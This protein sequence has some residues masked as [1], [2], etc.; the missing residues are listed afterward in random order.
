VRKR[1]VRV[2]RWLGKFKVVYRDGAGVRKAPGFPTEEEAQEH[3]VKIRR[4]LQHGTLLDDGLTVRE[5]VERFLAS[6]KAR[7]A[8]LAHQTNAK[9]VLGKHLIAA[10]GSRPFQ[11]LN[12]MVVKDFLTTG[13]RNKSGEP[14]APTT[15]HTALAILSSMFSEAVDD[16]QLQSNPCSGLAKKLNLSASTGE[17][18]HL[19]MDQVG[20][21]LKYALDKEPKYLLAVNLYLSSGMR[22]GE[23]LGIRRE[24]FD[25]EE[26]KLSVKRTM[27]KFG[28]SKRPKTKRSIRMIE[29]P[30]H[31]AE[32]I[33]QE[34]N[35]RVTPWLLAPEW[36]QVPTRAQIVAAR[37]RIQQ[38]MKRIT[39]GI[40]APGHGIHSLRHTFATLQLGRGA[41]SLW[42]SRQLGHS[43]I[44]MTTDTYGP[45]A[46]MTD[47]K[48]VEE[49][50]AAIREA[51]SKAKYRVRM[52][53]PQA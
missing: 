4:Q 40:H 23:G 46:E 47:R 9:Y 38:A 2:A 3:A 33:R 32:M 20:K 26:R 11:Q 5:Y 18:K 30:D 16:G 37:Q 19:T 17:A 1:S 34:F 53:Q 35:G 44:K 15:R 29:I 7:G 39:E 6:L 41:N 22:L 13:L 52:V 14:L 25:Y 43:S 28:E 24:D 51:V 48:G 12:R 21:M 10:Q 50:D 45:G 36:S 49:Q 42:V 8:S 31:L 27:S